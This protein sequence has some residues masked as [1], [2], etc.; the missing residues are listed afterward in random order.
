MLLVKKYQMSGKTVMNVA[1]IY[2][3]CLSFS[4]SHY[5]GIHKID[6]TNGDDRIATGCN[7]YFKFNNV[8]LFVQIDCIYYAT[9]IISH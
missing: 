7:I 9:I 8:T 5:Q 4:P 3:S 2:C 6:I 1:N